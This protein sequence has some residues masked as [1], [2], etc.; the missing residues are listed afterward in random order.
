MSNALGSPLG[1][2][3]GYIQGTPENAVKS[4]E[5]VLRNSKASVSEQQAAR[6][7]LHAATERKLQVHVV[8]TQHV[9]GEPKSARLDR[10]LAA[11]DD[12]ARLGRQVIEDLARKGVEVAD[13]ASRVGK[14]ALQ[15]ADDTAMTAATKGR[16]VLRPATKGAVFIGLVVDSGIRIRDGMEVELRFADGEINQRLREVAHARNAAGMVGGWGGSGWR[17]GFFR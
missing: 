9:L 14:S 12:T 16:K 2:S 7:V 8:Q 11:S 4:A 6:V 1:H 10:T 13:D 5:F 17:G 15:S 3:F